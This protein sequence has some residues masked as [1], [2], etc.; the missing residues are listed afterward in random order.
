[1]SILHSGKLA[2]GPIDSGSWGS[3]GKGKFSDY[4]ASVENL[5]F[6]ISHNSHNAS[7]ITVFD[8]PV[9]G[10]DTYK[11][12]ALP[13]AVSC[14]S[15]K[16]VMGADAA[17]QLPQML[18]EIEDWKMEPGRLFIHPNMPVITAEQI[19][20]EEE[21]LGCIGSTM[22]GVGAAKGHKV[23]RHKMT[24]TADQVPE[25]RPYIANVQRLVVEWLQQGQTGLLETAQ[26]FDLSMDLIF[27]DPKST[28]EVGKFYPACTS[29]NINP[30]AFAGM[31]FVPYQLLGSVILNLRTF[32]I[33]VGDGSN[34][35]G[36]IVFKFADGSE[37]GYDPT[38]L[39]WAGNGALNITV[40]AQEIKNEAEK[41]VGWTIDDKI[42]NGVI[43]LGSSGGCYPD[44][45]EISWEEVSRMTG[46]AVKEKTSLTKRIRRVFTRSAIQLRTSTMSCMPTHITINFLNYLDANIAGVKGPMTMDD[47]REYPNVH[48]FVK[49]VND[50]QFYQGVHQRAKIAYLGTGAKRSELIELI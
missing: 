43:N 46:N 18:K 7:H 3:G 39:V 12:N 45:Q 29:R 49:W 28:T 20:W 44:Q 41:F 27:D 1:M 37:K 5:D 21:N 14:C 26:G 30:S 15:T 22:S 6:A 17:V 4:L 38:T 50:T 35:G 2:V 16:V 13:S 24:R 34:S 25:L 23:M 19:K 32:P 47:L 36:S 40:T 42:F 31:S 11:F 8:E 48:E 9:N 33:R 10:F